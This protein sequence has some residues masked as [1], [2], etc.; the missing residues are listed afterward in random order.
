MDEKGDKVGK[1]RRERREQTNERKK[2]RITRGRR[3]IER[4]KREC[5]I[6]NGHLWLMFCF[7]KASRAVVIKSLMHPAQ[8]VGAIV[9]WHGWAGWLVGRLTS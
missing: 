2:R 9:C 1:K 8:M 3:K 7:A 5:L 6:S 4:I